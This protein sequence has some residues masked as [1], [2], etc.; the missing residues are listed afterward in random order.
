ML[1]IALLPD[2]GPMGEVHAER[3]GFVGG[4]GVGC[5]VG[6]TKKNQ[7]DR[8]FTCFLTA[9][10]ERRFSCFLLVSSTTAALP[11]FFCCLLASC[12]A[13][14]VVLPG[15]FVRLHCCQI[16]KDENESNFFMI[17]RET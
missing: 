5:N 8:W 11:V 1:R 7:F 9:A 2:D 3:F 4:L 15:R 16:Y 12:T 17:D 6:K 13:A 14:A 10:T